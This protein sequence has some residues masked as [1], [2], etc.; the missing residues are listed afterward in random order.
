LFLK[1]ESRQID[2]QF[3][4]ELAGAY[5]K[6]DRQAIRQLRA[7]RAR[8]EPLLRKLKNQASRAA[9]GAARP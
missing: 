7:M 2:A 6:N 4:N 5:E 9:T 1:D 3:E 8:T